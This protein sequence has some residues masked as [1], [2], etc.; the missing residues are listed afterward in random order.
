[1]AVVFGKPSF[2]LEKG[3]NNPIIKEEN[4]IVIGAEVHSEK[5]SN[6]LMFMAQAVRK[7]NIEKIQTIIYFEQ[8]YSENMKTEFEK[9]VNLYNKNISIIRISSISQLISY[10]NIG[11][12][13][14]NL[15]NIRIFPYKNNSIYKIKNIYIYSHGMPSRITFLLD[16]ETYKVNHNIQS[17]E[18]SSA[19]ELNLTNYMNLNPESFLDGASIWSYACRTG[20]SSEN[21]SDIEIFTWGEEESL[22]QKM[23]DFLNINIYAFLKRSSYEDTWGSKLDRLSLKIFDDDEFSNY[24]K[25]EKKIDNK[26]TWQPQGAYRDVKAGDTPHGPPNCL[27]LFRKENSI[28]PTCETMHFPLG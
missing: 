9:S 24:K 2:V 7:I 23:A 20:L 17:D 25:E 14:H 27:C 1:M 4:I 15:I 13:F 5:A 3:K 16:W 22:A 28:V 10:I 18:K 8:G 19:N 12:I 6:K 11:S 26:F 21:N